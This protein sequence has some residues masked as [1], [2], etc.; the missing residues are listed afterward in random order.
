MGNIYDLVGP[1]GDGSGVDLTARIRAKK[2]DAREMVRFG[3][4]FFV[5]L[6]FETLPDTFWQ[7]SLFVKPQDREV[8]CHASAWDIDG[9]LDLRIKMCI[10][11]TGEDFVTIHHELGHN[12]YQR[13]YRTQPFFFQ[14]S[15]TTASMKH[16]R[17]HRSLGHPG[18]SREGRSPRPGPSTSAMSAPDAPGLDK[19]AFLPFG[20]LA[21]SGAGRCSPEVS[22]SKYNEPGGPAQ[23]VPGYFAPV[24]RS[25]ADSIPA[26]RSRPRNTP[27]T[28]YFR[29]HPPF[30][31]HRALP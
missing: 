16:R 5:S 23:Q 25:E 20:L 4:R 28:R 11:P 2:L 15:A 13:A 14:N 21:T 22:E 26:P 6:G 3:E 8:V 7:R 31:F 30:Q 9:D 24:A 18:V 12:I 19:V 29:P 27:Y 1:Q 10:E 17:H